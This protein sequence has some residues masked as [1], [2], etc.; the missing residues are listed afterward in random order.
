[1]YF[2]L[3]SSTEEWFKIANVFEEKWQLRNC[4]G[5]INGKHLV[6]QPPANAGSRY[7]NYKHSHSNILLVMAGPSCECIFADVGTNGRVSDGNV[8]N[9]STI[10]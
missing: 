10:A 5:A 2:L 7:Y 8:W 6:M 9:K 3:P 4:L 1:M